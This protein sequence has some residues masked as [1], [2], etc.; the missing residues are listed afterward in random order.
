[1][2]DLLLAAQLAAGD[3]LCYVDFGGG[4]I[5][6]TYMCGVSGGAAAA[7]LSEAGPAVTPDEYV[8]DV[9]SL[10]MPGLW[11]CA[12]ERSDAAIANRSERAGEFSSFLEDCADEIP[13]VARY[14]SP[15]GRLEIVRPR[16]DNGFFVRVP[17]G[18]RG[19]G[20]FDSQSAANGW[21]TANYGEFF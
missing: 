1:M 9:T 15:A 13:V 16:G 17:N 18:L 3:M 2:F 8:F 12:E 10:E 14:T 5:D 11:A 6:L 20:P 4:P 7:A 19:Y 21:A